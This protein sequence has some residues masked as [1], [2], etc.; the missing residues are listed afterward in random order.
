MTTFLGSRL[1]ATA[2]YLTLYV[3]TA[4]RERS[5][6]R[7]A[8]PLSGVH[9][10]CRDKTATRSRLRVAMMREFVSGA[11]DSPMTAWPII[12][13]NVAVG[14]VLLI[15]LVDL[16]RQIASTNNHN[17]HKIIEQ[18]KA[19]S[20]ETYSHV[21][22]AS[23][24]PVIVYN[25]VPKTGSTSFVGLAY[26]LC[27]KNKYKVLHINITKNSHTLSLADQ[28]RFAWNLSEWNLNQAT[29]FHGH[30]AY[31]DF[32]KFSAPSPMFINIIR[33]P[34]DRMISYYYFLRYGDDFRPHL[35]RKKQG[36]KISFDECVKEGHAE[37]DP[38]NLWLQ[39]PFFCGHHAD[40]WIPGNKWAFQQAKS[41]LLNRYLVVGVTD[42][43]EEFVAVLEATL[44]LYFKGALDLYRQGTK[45]HLRKTNVKIPPKQETIAY[46]KNTTVWQ[47]ENEFYQFAVKQFEV[48]KSRTLN[49][50]LSDK[51]QQ[52]FY[53]KIRPK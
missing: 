46:F 47:L 2:R 28:L 17:N 14:V 29:F 13:F 31:L 34:L 41:N 37:C 10:T 44:P 26:E 8:S 9:L 33:Q 50:D 38:S 11:N 12:L 40:C 51:G 3:G 53:E 45:S 23:Q 43:M 1:E 39:V 15:F 52:F 16:E 49:T 27:S 32:S 48:I 24:N 35:V 4:A 6:L 18:V 7:D 5:H 30:L 20:Q 21:K 22:L 42:Q 36:N 19:Q 25:R